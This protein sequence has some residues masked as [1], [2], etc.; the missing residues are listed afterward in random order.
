MPKIDGVTEFSGRTFH[1][2]QWPREGVNFNG[3]R[4]GIIG[5]GSSAVQAIPHVAEQALNLTVF[6]RTANFSIP[7]HHGP[8]DATTREIH[9]KNY[10]EIRRAAYQTPFGIAKY[11]SP[12]QSALDVSDEERQKTYE[13]AWKRGGQALLFCYTDLLTNKRNTNYKN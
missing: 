11:G 12:T 5:T 9:K 13:D 6:Q 4:V 8:L 10:N 2:G 7:A 3:Q 1:T